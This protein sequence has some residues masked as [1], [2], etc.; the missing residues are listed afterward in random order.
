[1]AG[2]KTTLKGINRLR[3]VVTILALL[4]AVAH[5]AWPGVKVDAVTIALLA[6]AVLP[7]LAPLVKSVELPG[8]VKIELQEL[9][10]AASRADSAGLLAEPERAEREEQFSFE[11]VAARDPNLA[12]AGLRIEIERRLDRLAR[13]HDLSADMP[14]GVGQLLRALASSD[15]LTQGERSVLADMISLLNE[16]VHGADVDPRAAEWALDVGP[17]LLASLDE[18]VA[19]GADT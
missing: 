2:E 13:A 19:E 14:M 1:M 10:N 11:T 8:G 16:A 4:A 17:R 15:V 9:Q 6:I 18:R 7:W 12:L 5:L 3:W